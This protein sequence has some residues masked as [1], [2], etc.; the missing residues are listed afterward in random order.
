MI[1]RYCIIALVIIFLTTGSA[2]AGPPSIRGQFLI[3]CTQFTQTWLEL[4]VEVIGN[5]IRGF[6]NGKQVVEAT[7]NTFKAGMIG[8]WTKAGQRIP[9]HVLITSKLI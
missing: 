9:S 2:Y 7:D 6:L 5:H 1:N 8:L 4:R 3:R